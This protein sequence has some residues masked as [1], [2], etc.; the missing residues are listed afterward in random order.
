MFLSDFI[1][2]TSALS[3]AG[4][5]RGSL[6]LLVS[7]FATNA[8]ALSTIEPAGSW[9]LVKEK[10]GIVVE[11]RPVVGSELKESRG[12]V[13]IPATIDALAAVLE[14]AAACP[15]WMH[16]CKEG[17]SVEQVNSAERV[18]YSVIDAPYWFDD[19]DVYVRSKVRYQA[20]SGAL[21]IELRGDADYAPAEEGRVRVLDLM[22]SWTFE[23]AADGNTKATYQVYNN[24]QIDRFKSVNKNLIKT[25]YSTLSNLRELVQQPKY[26]NATF[27]AA[28]KAAISE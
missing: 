4:F 15:K 14:D 19:R 10:A 9:S 25:V 5:T 24:P 17:R 13:L 8:V 16:D 18:N 1:P 26:A 3:K 6:L 21:L 11:Q 20:N 28:L 12:T 22:A 23:P 2:T 7:L 27:D